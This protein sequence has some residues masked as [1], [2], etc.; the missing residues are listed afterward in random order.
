MKKLQFTLSKK[1]YLIGVIFWGLPFFTYAQSDLQ[2]QFS[3]EASIISLGIAYEQPLLKNTEA[4]LSA[5]I[6][7]FFKSEMGYS[8]NSLTEKFSPYTKVALRHYYNRNHRERKGKDNSFNKGNFIAFQNKILYGATR[9]N[10]IRMI[11]EVHWGVQTQLIKKLLFTFHIGI[12][13]YYRKSYIKQ[14]SN[15]KY[16]LF[17]PTLGLKL[18]YVLF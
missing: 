4:E 14:E 2:R 16:W 3:L 15:S 6:I 10:D 12:G 7:D 11:N 1:N 5:G 13:H 17:A 8:I 18:K 9:D